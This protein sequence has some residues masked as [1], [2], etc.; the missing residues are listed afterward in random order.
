VETYPGECAQSLKQLHDISHT[1]AAV[2]WS[3]FSSLQ[4]H[5]QL[6]MNFT[7]K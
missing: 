1:E 7:N 5:G 6:A 4:L 3:L 2:V